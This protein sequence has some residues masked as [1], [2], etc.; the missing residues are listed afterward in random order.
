MTSNKS[1]DIRIKEIMS[2]RMNVGFLFVLP[3]FAII[4]AQCIPASCGWHREAAERNAHS[5]AKELGFE[6]TTVTC[7]DS[8]VADGFVPCTFRDQKGALHSYECAG[9]SPLSKLR[10]CRQPRHTIET[11][12]H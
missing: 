1:S 11:E 6:H 5:W 7:N 9:W 8:A 10:G 4:A 2:P 12:A 3:I